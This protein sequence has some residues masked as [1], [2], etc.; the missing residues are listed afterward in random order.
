MRDAP[1]LPLR[2]QC[3]GGLT[4]LCCSYD[5]ADALAGAYYV[6]IG[7]LDVNT[8]VF[9]VLAT[10]NRRIMIDWFGISEFGCCTGGG[11]QQHTSPVLA[12]AHE[13]DSLAASFSTDS[14]AF[15]PA[16]QPPR[17]AATPPKAPAGSASAQLMSHQAEQR[18]VAQLQQSESPFDTLRIDAHAHADANAGADAGASVA[19][20]SHSSI[21]TL[22]QK[23]FREQRRFDQ[24][25]EL[26]KQ[27]GLLS[28]QLQALKQ[29]LLG[30][31]QEQKQRAKSQ[32]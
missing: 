15:R 30:T 26:R 24:N 14:G 22:L 1:L 18:L 19:A 17:K 11:S 29:H 32:K 12:S 28:W 3:W 4:S 20:E 13:P 16:P 2:S 8:Y 31:Q 27:C 6:R 7:S 5:A 23:W 25:A 9:V 10:E 21:H